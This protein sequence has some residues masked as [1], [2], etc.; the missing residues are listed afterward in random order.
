MTQFIKPATWLDAPFGVA[1]AQCRAAVLGIPFDCGTHPNRIG[2]RLGPAAIREQSTN[3]RRFDPR[4]N[5]DVIEH[6]RLVDC[7]DVPVTPSLIDASFAAI[8]DALGSV[9]D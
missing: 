4:N 1:S 9:I 5:R 8:E 3:L 6:L 7:G 2:S